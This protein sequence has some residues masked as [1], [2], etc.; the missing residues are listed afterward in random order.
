MELIN[1]EAFA[2]ILG[3]PK[4]PNAYL[5]AVDDLASYNAE[6]PFA[7]SITEGEALKYVNDEV[8][9]SWWDAQCADKWSYWGISDIYDRLDSD[10]I[11][12]MLLAAIRD[13][14]EA[15]RVMREAILRCVVHDM[16]YDAE[17]LQQESA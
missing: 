4:K 17:K 16:V 2:A 3:S 7:Q 1:A 13:P 8:L 10:E 15:G 6:L 5:Q 11:R 9:T 12:T 14:K